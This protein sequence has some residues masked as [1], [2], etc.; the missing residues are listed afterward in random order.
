MSRQSAQPA[1]R[2]KIVCTAQPRQQPAH[3]A[4]IKARPDSHVIS[5][6]DGRRCHMHCVRNNSIGVRSF[7]GR[8]VY[9]VIR[10]SVRPGARQRASFRIQAAAAKFPSTHASSR[11][12]AGAG[13]ADVAAV[14]PR[15]ID[16]S[17]HLPTPESFVA[18]ESLPF[19]AAPPYSQQT[20]ERGLQGNVLLL[21]LVLSGAVGGPLST[22]LVKSPYLVSCDKILDFLYPCEYFSYLRAPTL[23]CCH[24]A[25]RMASRACREDA[26]LNQTSNS[27]QNKTLTPS[28]PAPLLSIQMDPWQ[29]SLQLYCGK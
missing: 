13:S 15:R 16:V 6:S 2:S 20:L 8:A 28:S 23:S 12:T 21:G 24:P 1:V 17:P 22:I 9:V 14:S 27:S 25:G 26:N 4:Q 3:A 5:E 29:V 18:S 11:A 7:T 19:G 10:R